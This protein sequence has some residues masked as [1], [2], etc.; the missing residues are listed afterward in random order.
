MFTPKTERIEKIYKVQPKGVNQLDS[1]FSGN[2]NMYIDYANVRPWSVPL[3]WHIHLKRLKQFADS[4]SGIKKI[5]FYTGYLIGDSDSSKFIKDVKKCKYELRTKPVKIMRYSIDTSSIAPQS[6]DLINQF[7]R[8]A[9]VRRL[10]IAE[11][12]AINRIL[13]NLNRK[14]VYYI[15]DRKCNFDVELG[16]D[17][18]VDLK[19]NNVDTYVLWSGDSDFADPIEQ[20]LDAGKNV[21]LFATARRVS[22]E[23]GSLR[24]KGL[25][26]FDIKKIKN[27]I[28]R[29]NECDAGII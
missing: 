16:S 27:Y 10:E 29:P 28:C 6:T 22:A 7:M 1:I 3:G 21:I 4:F 11:I 26:I 17:M 5:N 20:L 14:G 23:L 9:L 18:I 15:E 19:L 8:S 2:I 13:T 25:F 12:E 24:G